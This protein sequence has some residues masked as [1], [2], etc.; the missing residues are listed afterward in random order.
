M[1]NLKPLKVEGHSCDLLKI[2]NRVWKGEADYELIAPAGKVFH[3]S[4]THSIVAPTMNAIKAHAARERLV[5][6]DDPDCD[7]CSS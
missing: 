5:D 6:C 2:P 4:G 7:I 1:K 3:G